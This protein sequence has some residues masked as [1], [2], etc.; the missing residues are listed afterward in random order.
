M[1][2]MA[3][4]RNDCKS[5]LW[6]SLWRPLRNLGIPSPRS[7]LLP[8]QLSLCK[9]R[10]VESTPQIAQTPAEPLSLSGTRLSQGVQHISSRYGAFAE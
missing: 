8:V 9:P 3:C 5:V 6:R 1:I 10:V 2:Q 4:S 7:Q